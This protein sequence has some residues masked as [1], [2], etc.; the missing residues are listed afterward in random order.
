MNFS[1]NPHKQK[2]A[3]MEK[4][5]QVLDQSLRASSI[6][7]GTKIL[8][9][10]SKH[11]EK[12]G[13]SD[14]ILRTW[15]NAI[16]DRKHATD[17]IL[18][19]KATVERR[20][21]LKQL[22]NDAKKLI[23]GKQAEIKKLRNDFAWAMYTNHQAEMP[24]M[25]EKVP[26]ITKL[27]EQIAAEKAKI[28]DIS[29]ESENA[30]FFA[31][32]VPTVKTLFSKSKISTTEMQL[33]KLVQDNSETLFSDDKLEYFASLTNGEI[34]EDLARMANELITANSLIASAEL[35][36]KDVNDETA[37]NA[38]K[39]SQLDV[40]GN[41]K[42]HVAELMKTIKDLDESIENTAILTCNNVLNV[43]FDGDGK[44]IF[45]G[46]IDSPYTQQM[47]DIA[48]IRRECFEKRIA[49]EI[50]KQTDAIRKLQEKVSANTAKIQKAEE[51]K[52]A[53]N[54]TISSCENE[55]TNLKTDISKLN[56]TIAE[57]KARLEV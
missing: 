21:Q 6:T 44:K 9:D 32:F 13:V 40:K 5:L 43:F 36:L 33:K 2:I 49:V 45:D 50:E 20:E 14:D 23:S 10:A 52:K 4:E 7:L 31:K 51:Q 17:T 47:T 3:D 12:L 54:N 37:E 28:N 55:N 39:L 48:G 56:D 24:D 41:D 25:A 15:N 26:E 38:E 30:N 1:P 27:E 18:T 57:L 29:T 19:I 53:L 8:T 11:D 22:G 46:E 34:A 42:Q 16:T 35:K